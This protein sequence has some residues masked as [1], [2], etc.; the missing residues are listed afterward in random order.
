MKPDE[1]YRA[2][3][4]PL[5][6]LL[7]TPTEPPEPPAGSH[8]S[9][10]VMRASPRFLKYRLVLLAIGFSSSL[11]VFLA[12]AIAAAA[13][14]E[15]S[16]LV[17]SV[18][19]L[20]VTVIAGIV[21]Y[22]AIRIDYALRFY[23]LTDRSLRV[24][25]GAFTVREL[26]LTYANVQNLS[27]H[28]GPIQRW[29]GISDRRIDT[30]GGGGGAHEGKKGQGSAH[31][32]VIAGVENAREIREQIRALMRRHGGDS[33]LGDPD[34]VH[35]GKRAAQLDTEALAALREVAAEARALRVAVEGR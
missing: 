28:Q 12:F 22:L 9:V 13:T 35:R 30:A 21:G 5:L 7:R 11:L 15:T 34:D 33:G 14:G 19:L 17:L 24:R 32:A 1:V 23:V 3:T 6:R 16:G 20:P 8:D 2:T 29:L 18:L 27:L 10:V 31:G 25:H 26:T 4:G